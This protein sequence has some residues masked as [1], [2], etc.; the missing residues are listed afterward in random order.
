VVKA[1]QL[2]QRTPAPASGTRTLILDYDQM[3]LTR[4][5]L[6]YKDLE[7]GAA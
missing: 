2:L 4:K 3:L 1:V 5:H 6:G 7:A